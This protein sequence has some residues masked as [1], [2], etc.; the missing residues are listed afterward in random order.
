MHNGKYASICKLRYAEI[1]TKHAAICSTKYARN[2]LKLQ[3]RKMQSTCIISPNI[4]KYA[5]ICK[6]TR[7]TNIQNAQTCKTKYAQIC[8]FKICINMHFII[9]CRHYM[10]EYA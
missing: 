5:H 10:L 3:I 4:K 2:M 6:N 1:C 9:R 7:C 8:I